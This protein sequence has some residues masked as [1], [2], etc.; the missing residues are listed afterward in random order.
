[1]PIE[2]LVI[3][4]YGTAFIFLTSLVVGIAMVAILRQM[5][6]QAIIAVSNS[7]IARQRLHQTIHTVNDV[8][9]WTINDKSPSLKD[10]A[11]VSHAHL[12][13]TKLPM[14]YQQTRLYADKSTDP[15]NDIETKPDIQ[16]VEAAIP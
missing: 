10:T 14:Q 8:S 5:R 13:P 16:S 12:D 15:Q 6:L 9:T 1:M 2:Y 3:L 7:Q 4:S 11:T